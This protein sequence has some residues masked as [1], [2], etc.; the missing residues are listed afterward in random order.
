MN[1]ARTRQYSTV[2][3]PARLSHKY[4]IMRSIPMKQRTA[5]VINQ[6]LTNENSNKRNEIDSNA[7]VGTKEISGNVGHQRER[8]H[9][10]HQLSY[11]H[12]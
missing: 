11:H 6:K 8:A 10:E 12:H 9:E 4:S 1:V 2:V 7:S 5:P 3:S